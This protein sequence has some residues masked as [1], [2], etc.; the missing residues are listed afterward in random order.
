MSWYQREQE[1]RVVVAEVT[2][3][4]EADFLR[5][6][7]AVHGIDAAVSAASVVPS[8]DFVQGLRITV[9]RSDEDAARAILG[10]LGGLPEIEPRGAP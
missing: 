4:A 7:L 5:I 10:G 8:V 6:S 9:R 1:Q 2:N 3:A